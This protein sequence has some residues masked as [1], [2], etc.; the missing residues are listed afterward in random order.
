MS[1]RRSGALLGAAVLVGSCALA[2]ADARVEEKARMQMTGMIGKMANIFGGKAMREGTT[3]I[4][5][6]KGDRLIKRHGD[7]AEMVDLAEEKIYQIDYDKKSYSVMTFEQLRQ[8]MREAMEKLKEMQQPPPA[9]KGEP[10][11]D[12]QFDVDFE[13]KDTGTK[14]KVSGYDCRLVKMIVTVRQ[15]GKKL[16]EAGGTVL[17]ADMWLGPTIAEKKEIEQFELRYAKQLGLDKMVLQNAQQM[18]AMYQA[19][20]GMQQAM[21][22]FRKESVDMSGTSVKTVMTVDLVGEAGAG[23][24]GGE[25]G[26]GRPGLGGML[27]G[28]GKMFKKKGQDQ[29]PAAKP[30]PAKTAGGKMQRSTL[31]TS[32]NEIISASHAVAAEEVAI[33]A[34]FKEKKR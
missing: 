8:Q 29:E 15:K 33:P 21:E 27:G 17:T 22:K 14:E 31:M 3:S 32:T 13:V 7:S 1:R 34:G 28:L 18:M 9:E 25:E 4:D 24:E 20:P 11:Q 2:L 26:G 19:A 6:V 30:E 16:E 10:A 12:P 5:A 23:E